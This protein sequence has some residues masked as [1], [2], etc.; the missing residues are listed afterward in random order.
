MININ[1]KRLVALLV[2]TMVVFAG[3]A[4]AR[5][6]ELGELGSLEVTSYLTATVEDFSDAKLK[7]DLTGEIKYAVPL[8]EGLVFKAEDKVILP[9]LQDEINKDKV[10]NSL[11]LFI[12]YTF[13]DAVVV[14]G[15]SKFNTDW[16]RT[17]YVEMKITWF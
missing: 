6:F 13:N 4:G 9:G 10:E 12:E 14:K 3:V 2:L 16:D 8:V 17:D 5:E 11:N 7:L 1:L 15:G